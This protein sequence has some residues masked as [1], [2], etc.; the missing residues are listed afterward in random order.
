MARIQITGSTQQERMRYATYIEPLRKQRG[1]SQAELAM[2]ANA[3]RNT[4]GN[5]EAGK[6]APQEDVLRRIFDVLG[7]PTDANTFEPQTEEWLAML[8]SLIESIDE[9]HRQ[10]A[11]YEARNG[12]I[13]AMTRHP[14]VGGDQ[15]ATG[16]PNDLL[17]VEEIE[18][19]VRRAATHD[20]TAPDEFGDITPD[21]EG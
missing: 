15:E 7:M 21:S 6:T 18:N 19:E 16:T 13:V 2:A 9:E 1:L 5:Y 11:V 10:P 20:E 17:T 8:G 4:I 12:L 14:N 3:G